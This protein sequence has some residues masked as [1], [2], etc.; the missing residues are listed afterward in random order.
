MGASQ[1]KQ[2]TQLSIKDDRIVA[3]GQKP[4]IPDPNTAE[5]VYLTKFL[6]DGRTDTSFAGGLLFVTDNDTGIYSDIYNLVLQ[7]DRIL[8][9]A[10]ASAFSFTWSGSPNREFGVDGKISD[11]PYRDAPPA[12]LTSE[13]VVFWM[14]QPS[15]GFSI[16]LINHQEAYP[17]KGDIGAIEAGLRNREPLLEDFRFVSCTLRN[18]TILCA[19]AYTVDES[20]VGPRY[21]GLLVGLNAEAEL[22]SS[23]GT[24]GFVP[25]HDPNA[26]VL[27]TDI[28]AISDDRFVVLERDL[29]DEPKLFLAVYNPDGSLDK[30]FGDEGRVE[31]SIQMHA[32]FV[33]HKYG[34]VVVAGTYASGHAIYYWL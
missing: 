16:V 7:D 18:R 33:D 3:L 24:G 2:I 17:P 31:T 10:M 28:A 9:C 15:P 14:S 34:R 12:F 26:S 21:T 1:L 6:E 20:E 11:L 13:D 8:V 25:R 29:L 19:G 4:S 5:G 30:N 23:F 27:N 32:L 22:D